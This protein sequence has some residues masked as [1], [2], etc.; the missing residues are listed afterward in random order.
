MNPFSY[1]RILI[2]EQSIRFSDGQRDQKRGKRV[3]SGDF[4]DIGILVTYVGG[5]A[6]IVRN[7]VGAIGADH[8]GI[9]RDTSVHSPIRSILRGVNEPVRLPSPPF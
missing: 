2:S 7:V 9:W 1:L 6:F 3:W 8:A 5:M 4:G